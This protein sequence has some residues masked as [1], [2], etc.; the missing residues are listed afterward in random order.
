MKNEGCNA[1]AR[2]SYPNKIS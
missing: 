2:N 1:V